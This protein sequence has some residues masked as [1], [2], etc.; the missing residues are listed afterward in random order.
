MDSS[1][2][3]EKNVGSADRGIR[4]V[5]VAA[6]WVWP[7]ATAVSRVGAELLGAVGGILL[8]TAITQYCGL[9]K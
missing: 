1:R 6:L 8:V 9:Y 2:F 3:L 4:L 5:I 7:N